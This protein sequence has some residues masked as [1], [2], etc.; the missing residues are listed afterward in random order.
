ML[1]F[2]GVLFIFITG[3]WVGIVLSAQVIL[4]DIKEDKELINKWIKK[5]G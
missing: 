4:K 5:Y 2:L 1:K 3:V